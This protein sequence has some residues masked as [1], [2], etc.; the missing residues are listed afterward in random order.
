MPILD[1]EVR[2]AAFQ[3]PASKSL[4]PNGFS[5]GFFFFRIIGMWEG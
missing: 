1:E 3:I 5:S 4:G 2:S